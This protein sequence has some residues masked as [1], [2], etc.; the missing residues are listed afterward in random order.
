MGIEM[1]EI[2][3][4]LRDIRER[5]GL[6]LE[7]VERATRIR[8][9]HLEAI[10]SGNFDSLPSPVQAR[11]FL[12]N[13]AEFLGL[14]AN[15]ILLRYAEKLQDRRISRG[16]Q[17]NYSEPGTRP[18]VEIRSRRPRWLSMDLF[19]AAG[20]TIIILLVLIWGGSRVMSSLREN[21]IPEEA[22]MDFL[23]PT[24]TISPSPTIISTQGITDLQPTL[25]SPVEITPTQAIFI[26]P[27][28]QV[29]IQLI[30]E[31][32]AWLQVAVDGEIEFSGRM[33]AGESIDF[34]ADESVKVSTGNGAGVRVIYNGVDQGLLGE[35]GQVVTRIWTLE[36]V[37]I[38]TP[39]QTR[40]P[41]ATPTETHSPVPSPTPPVSLT[42][43][44]TQASGG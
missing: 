29:S 32:R 35:L 33:I 38:P 24:I 34:V 13:Y 11:G 6:T 23:L 41:T 40:T 15:S 12:H 7:E 22:V 1:D 18:S 21:S 14:D 5:L 44:Q 8:I 26:V 31:I 20:I 25:P 39:T 10:E 42:P 17:A 16:A 28:S 36:G 37:L 3:R 19:V 4:N 2:G 27:A 30:V 43:T 9:H